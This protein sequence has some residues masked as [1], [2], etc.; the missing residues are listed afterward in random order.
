MNSEL[1]M[2]EI[3]TTVK[4][5]KQRRMQYMSTVDQL[6][7]LVL[8]IFAQNQFSGLQTNVDFVPLFLKFLIL[9][10]AL[11]A[12]ESYTLYHLLARKK[13]NAKEWFTAIVKLI[14][15]TRTYI[16]FLLVTLIR[17]RFG[18][19]VFDVFFSIGNTVPLFI[20]IIFFLNLNELSIREMGRL[21]W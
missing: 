12:V 8:V 5:D 15:Y 17:E 11:S 14:K 4:E 7:N 10:I 1:I 13:L 9:I 6:A 2:H 21:F 19:D 3:Q 16:V 18:S 20:I